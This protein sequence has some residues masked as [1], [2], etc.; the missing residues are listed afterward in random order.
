MR[1]NADYIKSQRALLFS[2]LFLSA[3]S[4]IT[5]LRLAVNVNGKGFPTLGE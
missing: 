3:N 1:M 4:I 2:L 5:I